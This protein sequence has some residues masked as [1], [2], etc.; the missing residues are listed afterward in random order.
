MIERDRPAP[1]GLGELD[2]V[3]VAGKRLGGVERRASRAATGSALRRRGRGA[4]RP[5]SAQ[6]RSRRARTPSACGPSPSGNVLASGV[7]LELEDELARPRGSSCSGRPSSGGDRAGR[8]EARGGRCGRV[9]PSASSAAAGSDGCA[10]AQKS[11]AKIACSR[12]S[13]SRAWQTS[14][15]CSRH[16]NCRRQ[17]QQRVDCSRLPPIVPMLRSCGEAA[18]RQASRSASGIVASCSSSAS[19]VPA[20]IAFPE[21]R[22]AGRPRIST[23]ARPARAR[24]AAAARAPCRPPAPGRPFAV[25][26]RERLERARPELHA[27][28]LLR[29]RASRRARSISSR[30]IGSD[31]H[32]GAG[33]VADRVRD[34]RGDRDDRRLAEPLRP[35]VRQVLVRYVDELADDLGHVGDRRQLVRVE[36]RA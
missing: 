35:E 28:T 14:P 12:C 8:A 32:V 23:S 31:V 25:E 18:R 19:V 24:R 17:Y 20:P 30:V 29:S 5:R 1:E 21:R 2:L 13:P 7:E 11:F 6:R 22:A 26:R 33:R 27:A 10:E 34:R 4:R 15:P 3:R 16:G 9:A 36:R